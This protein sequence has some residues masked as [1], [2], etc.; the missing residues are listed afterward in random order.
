M[1]NGLAHVTNIVRS[2]ELNQAGE[3]LLNAMKA[4][5]PLSFAQLLVFSPEGH[6]LH[7]HD[8]KV[9]YHWLVHDFD[10]PFAH[11]IQSKQMTL[12]SAEQLHY[13]QNNAAFRHLTAELAPSEGV[14][15]VPLVR[16]QKVHAVLFL[17]G[18][19]HAFEARRDDAA[20]SMVL[21]SFLSHWE[22]LKTLHAQNNDVRYLQETVSELR[23]LS[24]QEQQ[25]ARMAET[26]IGYSAVMVALRS[27]LLNAAES[28][29]SVLLQGET[30]SGKELAA[31]A[32]HDFS[33]R[34]HA[35]FV[36]INCA[37]IPETLLESELFGYVKG[38]FSGADKDTEGLIAKAH[39]GTLFLDEIGDMPLGLQ[40]KLL[41]VL[42]SGYYR[43]VGAKEERYSDFRLVSATHVQLFEHVQCKAF[44]QDLYYRLLQFPVMLPPLRERQ[45]DINVLCQTFV[46][47]YNQRTQRRVRGMDAQALTHMLS[48]SFPGNVRELKHWVD[49]ACS[50][51]LDDGMVPRRALPPVNNTPNT[52]FEDTEPD[53]AVHG[54]DRMSILDNRSL[55]EAV[56]EF[57]IEFIGKRLRYF[58]GDRQKTADS[59]RMPKR[60]L[61]Y[62]CQKWRIRR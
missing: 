42:E 20:L 54:I 41:R 31:R 46:A 50:Q 18:D 19:Y 56:T 61:A 5:L 13:W 52:Q 7:A 37:A 6:K 39:G 58:E 57:E 12:L 53:R 33:P 36:A 49:F 60:T 21:D 59:L 8:G 44:R 15:I 43:P 48:H 45:E 40:A 2:R 24:T 29:M 47:Q 51:T 38:A 10:V 55:K 27:Q 1:E 32:V 9:A 23:Q 16:H 28:M 26:L 25:L 11:A 30:G 62:K 3:A 4:E 22:Q 14:C 35:H 34:S 17:M